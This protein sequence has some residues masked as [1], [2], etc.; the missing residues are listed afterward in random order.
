MNGDR[1][2]CRIDPEAAKHEREHRPDRAARR[3]D[4]DERDGHRQREV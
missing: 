3:H 4:P 1:A 2:R